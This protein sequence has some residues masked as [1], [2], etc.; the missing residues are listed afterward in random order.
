M[1]SPGGQGGARTPPQLQVARVELILCLLLLAARLRLLAEV[2][3][4]W[5]L[6]HA[7]RE[8]AQVLKGLGVA[9]HLPANMQYVTR[10][11]ALEAAKEWILEEESQ[12]TQSTDTSVAA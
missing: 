8:V 5:P 3:L 9:D 7:R 6:V 10:L 11:E 1:A 12:E 2:Q 4:H